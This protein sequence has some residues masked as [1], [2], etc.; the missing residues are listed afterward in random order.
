MN[1]TEKLAEEMIKKAYKTNV[2]IVDVFD[3]VIKFAKE[4]S[5]K[6]NSPEEVREL[7]EELKDYFNHAGRL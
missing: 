5:K 1:R 2:R 4:E 3:S 6:L 7:Y